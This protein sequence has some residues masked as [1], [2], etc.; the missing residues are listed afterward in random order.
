MANGNIRPR[1]KKSY[2]IRIFLGRDKEGKQLFYTE[3][4]RGK[5]SV[6]EMRRAELLVQHG[7]GDLSQVI[8]ITVSDYLKKWLH[9]S[10]EGNVKRR[11]YY[12]Y[13]DMVRRYIDGGIG[14]RLLSKLSPMDLQSFYKSLIERPLSAR[15]VRYVHNVLTRALRQAEAWG[16]VPR[17]VARLV[18]PPKGPRKKPPR[19][20]DFEQ[21]EKFIDAVMNDR[22]YALWILALDSGMRPEEYLGLRWSDVDFKERTVRIEQVLCLN[23]KGGGYYFD[24]P[25][26]PESLRTLTVSQTTMLALQVHRREQNE[27]R[28]QM[29]EDWENLDLVFTNTIGG[30]VHHSNLHRRHFKP[31]LVRA[32]LPSSVRIYDLRHTCATLLGVKGVRPK[33]IQARLGHSSIKTT[34]DI[35]SHVLREEG[36]IAG[37][38]IESA[39]LGKIASRLG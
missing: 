15:T 5:K 14:N 28:L 16:M 12:D 26:T 21:S 4:V 11:T 9:D 18:D 27:A 33:L 32:G 7:K 35:Y 34:M 10:V 31:A 24:E 29:G 20:L 38:V 37:N 3:T 39:I 25:K 36:E 19:A 1:G 13:E 17:N 8:R 30:P 23:R 22:F 6:A 2:Q